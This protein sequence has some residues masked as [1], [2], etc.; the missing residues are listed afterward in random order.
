LLGF[1]PRQLESL[2]NRL[3]GDGQLQGQTP[4]VQRSFHPWHSRPRWVSVHIA[5]DDTVTEHLSPQVFGKGGQRDGARSSHSDMAYRWGHKRVV[6]SMLV[7]LPSPRRPWALP[8]LLA[9][10]RPPERNRAP[11]TP[12]ALGSGASLHLR[13]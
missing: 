13:R 9:L 3:T 8:V 10:Y 2:R 1:G 5:R 12:G 6:R 4:R 7:Q 11:G